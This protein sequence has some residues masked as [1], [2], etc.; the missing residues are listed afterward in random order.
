MMFFWIHVFIFIHVSFFM[1]LMMGYIVIFIIKYK[2]DHYNKY[3]KYL[4]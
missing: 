2:I 4:K 3:M 1:Y